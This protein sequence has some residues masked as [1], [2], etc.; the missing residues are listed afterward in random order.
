MAL[1]G[2]FEREAS[3]DG[4]LEVTGADPFEDVVRALHELFA[5]DGVIVQLRAGEVTRLVDKS[6]RWERWDGTGGV[7]EGDE[8]ASAGQDVD[9]G[10]VR[11]ETDAIDD[12]LDALTLGDLHHSRHEVDRGVVFVRSP[13]GFV[14]HD[15]LIDAR[16]ARD[17]FL[18]LRARSPPP[19]PPPP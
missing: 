6:E 8:D 5:S 9:G 3:I 4:D 14:V 12:S 13:R 1:D 10:F 2:L 7:T 19:A 16:G 18:A 11:S 17:V 15:E